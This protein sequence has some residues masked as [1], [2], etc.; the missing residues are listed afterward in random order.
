MLQISTHLPCS[1]QGR[2]HFGLEVLQSILLHTR[3]TQLCQTEASSWVLDMSIGTELIS[4]RHCTPLESGPQ[5]LAANY[6]ANSS[7][8]K[9]RTR[10]ARTWVLDWNTASSAADTPM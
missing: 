9:A 2:E 8:P 4:T 6:H 3:R 1:N 10:G 7:T 5:S